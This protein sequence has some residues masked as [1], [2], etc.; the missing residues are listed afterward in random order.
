LSSA[1]AFSRAHN[2]S[3][4]YG[5]Y[6]ELL[7]DQGIEVVYVSL[8]NA[9]HHEWTIK[10]LRAG[11]H[12]LC[13]KPIAVSRQQAIEM[14]HVARHAGRVLVEAFMYRSHPLTS[15]WLAQVRGGAIGRRRAHG[16]GLLLH[17]PVAPGRGR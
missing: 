5:S 1:E 13:E 16:R 8:P 17:P 15:A 4:A 3:R 2:V 12:V 14:F 10:A 7:A 9:M 11:K 6:E